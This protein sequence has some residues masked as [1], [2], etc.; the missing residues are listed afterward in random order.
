MAAD[1]IPFVTRA[2]FQE[3][4]LRKMTEESKGLSGIDLFKRLYEDALTDFDAIEKRFK[5]TGKWT[6]REDRMMA[7][8]R[9]DMSAICASLSG[10]KNV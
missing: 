8:L 2:E 9:H 3:R 5:A 1:I 7:R 6:A 10:V 4:A